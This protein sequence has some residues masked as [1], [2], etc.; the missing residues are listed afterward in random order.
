[1]ALPVAKEKMETL[2][3]LL[4]GRMDMWRQLIPKHMTAERMVQVAL[5]A[6]SRNPLLLECTPESYLKA[7]IYCGQVGLEPRGPGGV[8]LVPYKNNKTG[9][10]EATPIT[11]Y[12]G[13]IDLAL[14]SGR[15]KSIRSNLV[16]EGDTFDFEYG[17]HKHLKHIP[18]LKNRGTILAA[19]S[20][21]TYTDG[22]FDFEVVPFEDLEKYRKRSRAKDSGPWVTDTEAMYRKT[23]IHRHSSW[24]PQTPELLQSTEFENRVEAGEPMSAIIDLPPEAVEIVKESP[25]PTATEK[26]EAETGKRGPGRPPKETAKSPKEEAVAHFQTLGY[27]VADMENYV[28]SSY[29]NWGPEEIE[30]LRNWASG[31]KAKEMK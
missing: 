31:L 28:Q 1:M 11:D 7:F 27:G 16:Y 23:A 29:A 22:D 8:W 3:K 6:V 24:L 12:R 13:K 4:G 14:R 19:Y 2:R 26:L 10:Y 25:L 21:A 15:I 18:A 30:A 20:Y 5:T 9:K 17:D